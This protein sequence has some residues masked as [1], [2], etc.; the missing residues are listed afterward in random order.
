M[1]DRNKEALLSELSKLSPQVLVIAYL[2]AVNYT[3]YGEDVTKD[4]L[5]ATQQSAALEKAYVKGCKDT[6]DRLLG[7]RNADTESKSEGI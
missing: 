3:R 5:T 7:G 1:D 4:W 2:Y 6:A